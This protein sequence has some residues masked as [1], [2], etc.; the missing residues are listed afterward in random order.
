MGG[1]HQ[2]HEVPHYTKYS[3]YQHI[4]ELVAHEKRLA[5]LGLKDPWIR[6]CLDSVVIAFVLD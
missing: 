6:F 1:V 5:A 2:P 3:N 4:P